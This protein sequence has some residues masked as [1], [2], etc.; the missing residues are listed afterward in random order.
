MKRAFGHRRLLLACAAAILVVSGVAY[1]A[2]PG[3]SGVINGCYKGD[4]NGGGKGQLRVIDTENGETC[5]KN[6]TALSWNQ[7]GEEGDT[8]A[9]GPQGLQGETGATGADGAAGLQGPAG[10][11]AAQ[12]LAGEPGDDGADGPTE[13]PSTAPSRVRTGSIR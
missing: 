5:K 10:P 4:D 3:G 1:A 11:A 7:K 9:Q 2:I 13:R 6:E 8:G 12:G